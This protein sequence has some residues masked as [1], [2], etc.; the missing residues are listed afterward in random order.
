MGLTRLSTVKDQPRCFEA[1]ILRKT[2]RISNK[3]TLLKKQ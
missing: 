3:I 1:V 2:W